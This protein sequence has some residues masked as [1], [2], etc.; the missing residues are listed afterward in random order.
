MMSRLSP[1]NLNSARDPL[2]ANASLPSN[3]GEA[4]SDVPTRSGARSPSFETKSAEEIKMLRSQFDCIDLDGS[5]V[6]GLEE[7]HIIL[8]K[9]LGNKHDFRATVNLC[10]K[11]LGREMDL[12]DQDEGL[13]FVEFCKVRET[14]RVQEA[15]A[16]TQHFDM[17]MFD[18]AAKDVISQGLHIEAD[19]IDIDVAGDF[20]ETVLEPLI[21]FL[22]VVNAVV[23]GIQTEYH[24]WEYWRFVEVFFCS[25]F[26]VELFFKIYHFSIPVFF[27]GVDVYWNWFD[28]VIVSFAIVDVAI[29]FIYVDHELDW[30]NQLTIFRMLRLFRLVRLI[31]LLRVFKELSLLVFGLIGGLRTLFWAI[32]LLLVVIFIIGVFC[33]QMFRDEEF[34]Y[35]QELFGSVFHSMFTIFRCL[36]DGCASVDGRPLNVVLQIKYGW[37]FV[38]PYVLLFMIVVFGLFNLII[39][40]FVESTLLNAK[41]NDVKLAARRK[42]QQAQLAQKMKALLRHICTSIQEHEKRRRAQMDRGSIIQRVSGKMTHISGKIADTAGKMVDIAD[43]TKITQRLFSMNNQD[44]ES[45][46]ED[47]DIG[48]VGDPQITTVEEEADNFIVIT[49]LTRTQFQASLEDKR[50]RELLD[51]LDVAPQDRHELFEV[52]DADNN[53]TLAISELV[54][55]LLRVRGDARAT[56]VVATRLSVR[57]LQESLRAFN[58]RFATFEQET[59]GTL[60]GL[61]RSVE[62]LPDRF[63]QA[64]LRPPKLEKR[65]NDEGDSIADEGDCIGKAGQELGTKLD[66][67]RISYDFGKPGQELGNPQNSL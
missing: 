15:G 49:E 23:I 2:G 34:P 50:V 59:W 66:G 33:T 60:K 48:D 35:K 26:F 32:M 22:I 16:G 12:N 30:V 4:M 44:M 53:G 39:S 24:E 28:F 7:M 65:E 25:I 5:G 6:L 14:I 9:V 38:L 45:K 21:G 62:E 8:S 47:K 27:C 20:I 17:L 42:R 54:S 31:R 10:Q 46:T 29:S 3:A 67:G 58:T 11:T 52:L 57:S 13:T 37:Y 1:V 56:D 18:E 61:H 43:P 19:D 36:T 55:G 40:V 63:L 51:A 41:G 64:L